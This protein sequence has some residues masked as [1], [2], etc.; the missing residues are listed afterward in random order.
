MKKF[1]LLIPLLIICKSYSQNNP[2]VY[3]NAMSFNIVDSLVSPYLC[4]VDTSGNLW[5]ASTKSV[6]ASAINGL[7]EAAPNDTSLHLVVA[8]ADSDSVRTI[9]GITAIGNDIF[10]SARMVPYLGAQQPY[11]YPYSEMI[12]LPD[13][14]PDKRQIFKQPKY[15]DYGTW[16]TGLASDKDGY[17]YFGQSYLVTIGSIDGRKSS[18]KFGWT[19]DYARKDYSTPMEPGGA[20]TYPNVVDLIRDVA[21]DPNGNY[22]DTSAAVFTSRNSSPD[23]GGS[24]KGGIAIW[25]GGTESNPIGYHAKRVND[26]TSFLTFGTSIPYGIAVNPQNG[27]LYVCGTDSTKKWVKGFQVSGNFAV[28]TDEL[29]S[30]TS[31]DVQDT[32]GAP[33]VAPAD[34]AFNSDGSV[35]Y[36]IDEGAKKV[37]KFSNK[38]TGIKS[39][40]NQVV[41]SFDLLQNYPNP[42]NPN[43]HIV[44]K[45]SSSMNVNAEVYNIYGQTI[46]TLAQGRF[47]AGKHILNFDGSRLASGVYICKVTAGNISRSVKMILLK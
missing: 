20:L 35:A 21:V 28:Q 9:T 1:L 13:G 29:P 36:V 37:F 11:Y 2:F 7:F 15:K 38:I 6:S 46:S 22:S 45:I 43:T 19:V 12:Y 24:G 41:N 32:S 26:L 27:Y 44:F 31:M 16:Y 47:S 34:V 18:Q 33:F 10:V 42:F 23:P 3:K 25:T 17:M 39:E 4:T 5:V 40:Y 30:S 14:N 8:F